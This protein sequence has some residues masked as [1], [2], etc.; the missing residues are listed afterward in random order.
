MENKPSQTA[1][2]GQTISHNFPL[3]P[4]EQVLF[5]ARWDG[6][7]LNSIAN[8]VIL[9]ILSIAGL[10]LGG[11][12]ILAGLFFGFL[13]VIM[14]VTEIVRRVSGR[15]VLTNQRIVV[16]G[17]PTIFVN[18]E[19]ALADVRDLTTRSDLMRAGTGMSK[20]TVISPSGTKTG[21]TIPHAAQFVQAYTA[22]FKA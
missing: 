2:G 9:G 1:Q 5:V 21:I 16:K 3:R 10:A 12:F 8:F 22:N 7:W 20:V 17:L 19:I 13:M 4:G 6:G 15:A 11:I 18:K 14:L